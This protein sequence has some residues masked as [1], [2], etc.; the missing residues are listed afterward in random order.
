MKRPPRCASH[1]RAAA[2]LGAVSSGVN[3]V[4]ALLLRRRFWREPRYNLPAMARR[5]EAKPR[6]REKCT[7][8]RIQIK[9]SR[10]HRYGV[11]ALE[12]IPRRK[13]V[14]EYAGERISYP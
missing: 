13:F 3:G 2:I 4:A 6:N 8:F 11:F 5:T 10:I 1:P 7:R 9:R 12:E 14:I